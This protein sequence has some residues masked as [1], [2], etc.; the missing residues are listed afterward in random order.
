[1]AVVL[2]R[3]LRNLPESLIPENYRDMF[4][5]CMDLENKKYLIML[6][7]LLLPSES[8]NVL[9]YLMP[10]CILFTIYIYIYIFP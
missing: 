8:V 2:K 4:L 1:M 9:A 5:Q 10:V 6:A 7:C 3:F